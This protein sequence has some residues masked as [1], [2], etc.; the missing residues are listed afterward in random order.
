MIVKTAKC[1]FI[2]FYTSV[3][4]RYFILHC[5]ISPV[6]V[7][8]CFLQCCI[9]PCRS[10]AIAMGSGLKLLHACRGVGDVSVVSDLCCCALSLSVV[11][12]RVG[13]ETLMYRD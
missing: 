2:S 10:A 11:G 3:F 8:F 6:F 13:G 7:L 1:K 12:V 5:C 4:V 9:C